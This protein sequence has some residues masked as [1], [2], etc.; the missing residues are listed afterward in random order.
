MNIKGILAVI[1]IVAILNISSITALAAADT[2]HHM[3]DTP[4]SGWG[5]RYGDRFETLLSAGVISQDAHEKMKAYLDENMPKEPVRIGRWNTL[6]SLLEAG[7]ITQA[8]YDALKLEMENPK[9]RPGEL[10]KSHGNNPYARFV[11]DGIISEDTAAAIMEYL[12]A[13]RRQ[14]VEGPDVILKMFEDNIITQAEYEDIKAYM[15][16]RSSTTR[17]K[18]RVDG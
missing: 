15:Q 18:S 3:P 9:A 10:E 14:K 5:Q 11:T 7:I 16:E 6:G 13:N 1:L 2:R 8:E 17:V 12:M 4:G